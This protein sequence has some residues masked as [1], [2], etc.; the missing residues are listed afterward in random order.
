MEKLKK[1]YRWEMFAGQECIIGVTSRI[2]QISRGNYPRPALLFYNDLLFY[3]Q[4]LE[5]ILNRI[6]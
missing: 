5:L 4:K 1:N 6:E 3:R 2:N